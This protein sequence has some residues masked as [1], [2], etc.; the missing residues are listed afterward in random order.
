MLARL[1]NDLMQLL[2]KT[3]EGELSS[4]VIDIDD[5]QAATVVLV[6]GGYPGDYEK[7]KVI[8]GIEDVEG[9]QIFHG[10]TDR[11]SDG[12]LVTAGGRVLSV[13][14][15]GTTFAEALAQCYANVE[16]IDF[17]GLNYRQDIGFDL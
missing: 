6:S 8:T 14:S 10:G 12:Q 11:K 16:K 13:T 4:A 5:R 1:N 2:L 9:S 17:E 15:Y 3:A 7:G